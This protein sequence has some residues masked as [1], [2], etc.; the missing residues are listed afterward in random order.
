[1]TPCHLSDLLSQEKMDWQTI[2]NLKNNARLKYL[3]KLD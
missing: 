2:K 3:L 1:M